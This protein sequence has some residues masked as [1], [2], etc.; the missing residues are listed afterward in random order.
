MDWTPLYILTDTNLIAQT[1]MDIFQ[2]IFN[3]CFPLTKIVQ[4][5]QRKPWITNGIKRASTKK[6]QLYMDFLKNKTVDVEL[7]F[8]T[9][10][11]KLNH[12]IQKAKK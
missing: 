7:T 5:T 6:H 12:I 10:R 9:Y 4:H 3:T 8:K 2:D 1:F 11:N